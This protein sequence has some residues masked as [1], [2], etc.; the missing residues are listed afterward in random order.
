MGHKILNLLR[1]VGV[2]VLTG[3]PVLANCPLE[4]SPPKVVVRHGDSVSVNCS[5]SYRNI[6]GM[7]W[8]ATKGSTGF[9]D[10]VNVVN[11]NVASLE[12]WTIS[13]KCYINPHDIPQCLVTLPVTLYKPPDYV[14]ISLLNHTDPVRE[15]EKYQ[16]QCEV[17]NVAPVQNL[18]VTWFKGN[19]LIKSDH[20]N[21]STRTPVNQSFTLSVIPSRYEARFKCVAQLNLDLGPKTSP[22][23]DGLNLSVWFPPTF[24]HP[25]PETLNLEQG[26]EITLNCTASGNPTPVYSWQSS[27]DFP[28]KMK[29]DQAVLTSLLPGTYNCTASNM[30]GRNTKQF[31]I[32]STGNRTTFWAIIGC[33]SVLACLI[34]IVYV[35]ITRKSGPN[36]VI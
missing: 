28:E 31:I 23:A 1:V 9:V 30:L 10:G 36:S 5:T 18:T 3:S 4:L 15:G 14:Y 24:L 29:K 34:G 8:E 6:D 22:M 21:D 16:L 12:D 26:D 2:I 32:K 20:Y 11:W 25:E 7:G 13:P 17:K 35:V 19:E 27:A 33:G